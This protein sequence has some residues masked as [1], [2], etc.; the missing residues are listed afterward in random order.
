MNN[1]EYFLLSALAFFCLAGASV[2]LL[3]AVKYRNMRM[4]DVAL[5]LINLAVFAVLTWEWAV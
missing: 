1:L 3:L 5:F 4:S 2:Q